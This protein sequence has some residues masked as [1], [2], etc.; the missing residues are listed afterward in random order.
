MRG[1]HGA[2][3]SDLDEGDRAGDGKAA[4]EL[5]CGELFPQDEDSHS[6]ANHGFEGG[7]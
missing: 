5:R 3:I 1:P 7:C 4:Q 6:P 2:Q